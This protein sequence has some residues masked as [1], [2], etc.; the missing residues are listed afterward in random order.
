MFDVD[1]SLNKLT[2][3]KYPHILGHWSNYLANSICL[4]H[5]SDESYDH[6]CFETSKH[7][8]S[9]KYCPCYWIKSS[10]DGFFS[11]LTFIHEFGGFESISVCLALLCNLPLCRFS[12]SCYTHLQST[13]EARTTV[14][15]TSRGQDLSS[16]TV[17]CL[18][19]SK[20]VIYSGTVFGCGNKLQTDMFGFPIRVR[21]IRAIRAKKKI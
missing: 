8:L 15:F 19:I 9:L 2:Q 12:Q 17:Q 5:I 7:Y 1:S 13:E 10:D 20:V 16:H 18:T 11:R 6:K 21:I 4:N 14:L 3:H